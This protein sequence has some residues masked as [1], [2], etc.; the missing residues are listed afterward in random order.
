MKARAW[1]V[2]HRQRRETWDPLD[3]RERVVDRRAER[4]RVC[5]GD[6]PAVEVADGP[7]CIF[8][9]LLACHVLNAGLYSSA[10]K[11]QPSGGSIGAVVRPCIEG[12]GRAWGNLTN[13]VDER[14][15]HCKIARRQAH[16]AS[17][18]HTIVVRRT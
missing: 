11:R 7:N 6:R 15:E 2:D 3:P 4:L 16:A 5:A 12:N 10:S 8:S 14:F 18:D 9:R 17:D 13:N 1:L